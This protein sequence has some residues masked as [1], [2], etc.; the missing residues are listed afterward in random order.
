MPAANSYAG[1]DAPFPDA[2]SPCQAELGPPPLL[3]L[4]RAAIPPSLSLSRCHLMG[5]NCLCHPHLAPF[6]GSGSRDSSSECS[7]SLAPW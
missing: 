5:L 6:G 4:S 2:P 7:R 1:L 3:P